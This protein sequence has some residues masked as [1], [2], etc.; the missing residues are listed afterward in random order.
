MK[1][2]TLLL[3][4][5]A[6]VV[7]PASVARADDDYVEELVGLLKDEGFGEIKISRTFLGRVRIVAL[8]GQIRRELICNPRTGEILRDVWLDA[9]GNIRGPASSSGRRSSG[10]TSGD[11]G[12]GDDHSGHGG[13][14]DDDE[15]DDDEGGDDS[16]K[17]EDD[18][19]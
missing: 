13:G 16:D 14:A 9:S 17:G 8:N 7:L 6:A 12:G 5:A 15:Q 3:G 18:D 2:R 11:D 10:G 1:R 4:L 19:E